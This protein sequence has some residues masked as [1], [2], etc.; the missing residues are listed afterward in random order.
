MAAL[1][2]AAAASVLMPLLA[3]STLPGA[4]PPRQYTVATPLA[5]VL[6]DAFLMTLMAVSVGWLPA[7]FLTHMRDLTLWSGNVLFYMAT[8]SAAYV[9]VMRNN[10]GHVALTDRRM[11]AEAARQRRAVTVDERRAH[12]ALA[13]HIRR[14]NI[15]ALVALVPLGVLVIFNEISGWDRK[16]LGQLIAVGP[17]A[18]EA[19]DA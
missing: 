5:S 2:V 7:F 4:A 9:Y 18:A 17:V 11:V 6:Q 19:E 15:L 8:L 13:A 14:Q 3:A 12:T 1:A 16:G 10:I